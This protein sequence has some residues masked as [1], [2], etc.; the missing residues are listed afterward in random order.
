[1]L[2][3][4]AGSGQRPFK[5]FPEEGIQWINIDGNPRWNP[6]I[7]ADIRDLSM[8]GD[9]M[10]D[11]VVLHHVWEHFGLGEG[12]GMI[13]ECHRILKPRGSLLVCIPNPRALCQRYLSGEIDEYIFN[14]NMYGAYMGDEADRHKWSMSPTACV[15]ALRRLADWHDVHAFNGRTIPGADIARD[16]WTTEIEAVK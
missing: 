3:I 2:G 6:D 13:R 4:N 14:V 9:S 8:F 5:S 7:V 1:M 10:V 15:E 16:W 12:D 11:L